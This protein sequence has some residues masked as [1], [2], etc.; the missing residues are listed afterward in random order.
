M[1]PKCKVIQATPET[2]AMIKLS[3]GVVQPNK[4]GIINW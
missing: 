3:S 2:T 1:T 4:A